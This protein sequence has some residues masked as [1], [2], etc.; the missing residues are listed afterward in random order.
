MCTQ[1]NAPFRLVQTKP[2]M[3]DL[4]NQVPTDGSPFVLTN[5]E[6]LFYR[7]GVRFTAA[8]FKTGVVVIATVYTSHMNVEVR[9]PRSYEGRTRGLFGILGNN[10]GGNDLYTREG[11][12]PL[13][14]SADADLF[15]PLSSCKISLQV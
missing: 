12:G 13:T 11:M 8:L 15:G 9:V 10:D 4:T 2:V 3:R 7:N 14:D 5:R 1:L 6:G